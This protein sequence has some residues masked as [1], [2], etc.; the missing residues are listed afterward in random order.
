MGR[1][2]TEH[3]CNLKRVM[4]GIQENGLRVHKEKCSS[5]QD[6]VE[7][8]GHTVDKHGI[9]MSPKKVKAVVEMPRKKRLRAFLCMLNHYGKFLPNSSD[10]CASLNRK[11]QSGSG[12]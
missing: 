2:K 10:L 11:Q 8:L 4:N 12:L 9:Q 3:L 7:Y 6:S 1:D 5:M